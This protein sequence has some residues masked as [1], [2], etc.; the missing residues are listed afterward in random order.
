V[1]SNARGEILVARRD[2]EAHQGGL[3]EFPGGKLE[4][5]EDAA[6]ALERELHEEIG[7]HVDSARP[8]IRVRHD[9]GDRAV[10]LD[11]WRVTEWRGPVRAREGQALRWLSPDALEELSMPAADVPIVRAIR[12]PA[13]YLIT[14]SPQGDRD[15][16][17]AALTASVGAGVR[18]VALRAPG[19]PRDALAALARE[20]AAI[21]RA[22]GATLLVNADADMLEASEADGVHLSSERLMAARVRPVP[23][24]VWLAASCHDA[25]E[26]AQAA[27][28]GVDF[29]VLSP[30]A[31]TASHPQAEPLGWPRFRQ[32]VDGVNLPV[33]ALG[34]M[35]P[36]DLARAWEQ[37][38][39]GIAAMRALW[40]QPAKARRP[41]PGS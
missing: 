8:L 16:F 12:L 22:G 1:L 14:P 17:F 7:I 15:A 35:Q 31:A 6:R 34:G 2:D 5:D 29:A 9:Y 25:A 28:V 38:A 13:R 33:F 3:W 26:L 30:V 27:R 4:A 23:D 19:L 40:R 24:D 11:V 20:A 21:C 18:L 39:Q 41:S 32:L 10:L 36:Q 37:G